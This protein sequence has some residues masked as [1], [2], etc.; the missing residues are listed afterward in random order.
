M[1]ATIR[2]VSSRCENKGSPRAI[3]SIAVTGI[4]TAPPTR[5]FAAITPDAFRSENHLDM[6]EALR[7]VK[8]GIGSAKSQDPFR[9][10]AT[11]PEPSFVW[12]QATAVA[13]RKATAAQRKN[14]NGETGIGVRLRSSATSAPQKG[15]RL[16]IATTTTGGGW[17]GLTLKGTGPA[18]LTAKIAANLP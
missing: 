1:P 4:R 7:T 13:P 8:I 17:R 18:A 6:S 3:T 15:A 11:R 9:S 10:S 2:S 12:L 14:T 16:R 5:M